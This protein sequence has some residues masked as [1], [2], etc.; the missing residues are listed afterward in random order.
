MKGIFI[1][2]YRDL[3]AILISIRNKIIAVCPNLPILEM[4][5]EH[6]SKWHGN[7]KDK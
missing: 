1:L 6:Y 7:I 4:N 5:L 3:S 2:L